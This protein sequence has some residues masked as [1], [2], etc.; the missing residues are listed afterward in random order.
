MLRI[1]KKKHKFL[2]QISN[3]S[4]SVYFWSVCV[5]T[6]FCLVYFTIETEDEESESAGEQE[7]EEE[8]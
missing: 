8:K 4:D 3:G 5:V 6:Y 1:F 7:P 2:D